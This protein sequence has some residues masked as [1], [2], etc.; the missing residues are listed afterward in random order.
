[1]PDISQIYLSD[2]QGLKKVDALLARE[3]LR[4]DPH[5]DYIC[6]IYDDDFQLIATGSAY[7]NTLRCFAV[8][9]E[10]QGEGLLNTIITHLLEVQQLRGNWSVFLYTKIKSAK[11]FRD[12]GFY[13]IAEIPNELVFMENQK[14]GFA[15]YLQQ[16]QKETQNFLQQHPALQ[17]KKISSIVMNANPFTLGHQYLI[18]EA[19]QQCDL[20]HLFLLSEDASI[21]PFAV[22]KQ[23]VQ[24]GI[25]D[26][27]NVVLHDSGPYIISQATFPDYFQNDQ[28][29]V[30][31]GHARLDIAIF[32]RIAAALGIQSRFVGEEPTSQIT[33][34]YNEVM[35]TELPQ[36]HIELQILPRLQ[37][38]NQQPISASTARQLL[39]DGWQTGKIDWQALR[40][41][42]PDTTIT[43]LQSKAAKPVLEKIGNAKEVRHH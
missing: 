24:A 20:L 42:L 1:M 41:Q 16:L 43:W 23:L 40:Q 13:P 6:G 9:P 11:F 2:K 30:N 31:R 12:L 26:L 27:P 14:Q 4:R 32:R 5:L 36:A 33:N 38:A 19:A 21:F 17:P 28:N 25:A 35:R 8:A 34:L 7:K 39:K 15:N 18:H 10:H 3:N 29:A 37:N 22:R